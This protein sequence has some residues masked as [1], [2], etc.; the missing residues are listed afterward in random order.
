MPSL[1]NSEQSQNKKKAFIPSVDWRQQHWFGNG[2]T[3]NISV[4]VCSNLANRDISDW[5]Q[6]NGLIECK[7]MVRLNAS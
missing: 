5:M 4:D 7:L 6:V 1:T 2:K 3:L